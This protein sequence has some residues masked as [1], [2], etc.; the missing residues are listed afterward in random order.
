MKAA[1][2]DSGKVLIPGKVN[3]LVPER[4]SQFT[5]TDLTALPETDGRRIDFDLPPR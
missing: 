5:T 2:G 4:Y 3:C 1:T